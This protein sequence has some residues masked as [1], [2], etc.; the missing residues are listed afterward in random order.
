MFASMADDGAITE[1]HGIS[2]PDEL[3]PKMA[4]LPERE[5]KFVWAYLLSGGK[6]HG[7]EAA[8]MA[9]YSDAGE[10]A[11]VRACLL[12]QRDR[13]LEAMHEVAWKSGRGLGLLAWIKLRRLVEKEDHPDHVK[14]LAM[15]LARTFPEKTISEVN[16]HGEVSVNHTDAAL[17][18]LRILKGLGVPREKLL[19]AFGH[20]GLGRYEKMLA[21]LDVRSPKLIEGTVE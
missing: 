21:E 6:G 13:V 10:G 7:A 1:F 9:G 2:S 18:Q 8:R 12:L 4:A 3:G 16:I 17:E 15:A 5:R 11:K 20:S 14:G 19:E